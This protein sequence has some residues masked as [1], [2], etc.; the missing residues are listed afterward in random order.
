MNRNT[1][2]VGII[3]SLVFA[4]LLFPGALT[5]Q[6][7]QPIQKRLDPIVESDVVC[8]YRLFETTNIWTFILLDT[9]T[10]RTWQI[11]YSTNKNPTVKTFINEYSLLP[12]GATLK[13]GR[14]TLYPTHNLYT[15]LLFDRE[16][17]R[18]WQLQWSLESKSR[19]IVRTILKSC[20]I[21][22]RLDSNVKRIGMALTSRG[23]TTFN[24]TLK[25][26]CSGLG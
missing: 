4:K 10:G 8:R 2:R 12:K 14:F 23:S 19:G 26:A 20:I 25:S 7:D 22:T 18:I 1:I 6:S 11:H 3:T 15:F 17:S 24:R 16:D 9:A 13:N 21:Q 5:A